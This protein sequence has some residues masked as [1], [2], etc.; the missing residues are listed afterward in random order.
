MARS[1]AVGLLILALFTAVNPLGRAQT[2]SSPPLHQDSL[3]LTVNP[4]RSVGVGLNT[5]TSFPDSQNTGSLF[6]SEYSIH[7]SSNFSQQANAVVQTT[8][9]QYQLPSQVNGLVDSVSLTAT[10]AGL[11]GHG[12]L[13]ISTSLPV[14]N[15]NIVYAT[16]PNQIQINATAQLSLSCGLFCDGTAFATRNT[17]LSNW[18]ATFDN[19]TWRSHIISQIQNATGHIITVTTFEG[20]INS[21]SDTSAIVSIRFVAVPSSSATDFVVALENVIAMSGVPASGLDMIIRSALNL[22]TGET[23]SL[24]YSKSTGELVIQSTTNYVSDLDAQLNSI[25]NQY[26]QT[27]FAPFRVTGIPIPAQLLFLNSTSITVSKISTTSDIDLSA[28]TSRMI[29]T[30][31][32]IGPPTVGTPSNFTIPG[33]FHTIGT[34]PAPGVSLTLAGGSNATYQVKV[35]VP[36]GTPAPSSTTANSATWTNLQ[37]F[38]AL[39]GV[40]FQLLH[41]SNSFLAVLLSPAGLA[42][43]AVAAAAIV[44]GGLFYLRKRRTGMPAPVAPGPTPAPGL[45][46][47]PTPP[48]Q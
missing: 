28:G 23:L 36:T 10:Q 30:G 29:L 8:V 24:T 47:S 21:I 48:T 27:I 17:F 40:Q 20:T 35:V 44:A 9:V 16:S 6:Q 31:F 18:S 5:T 12:S 42:I 45:G 19:P 14:Q 7:S 22:E 25:K 32:V 38:S 43:E 13:T 1:L 41:I 33:L 34:I 46:P 11:S 26:F 37:D 39:S 4:D 15:V 3:L 2:S